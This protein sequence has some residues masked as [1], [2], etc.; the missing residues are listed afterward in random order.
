MESRIYLCV[1]AALA[2]FASPAAEYW[3]RPEL[4]GT[5]F[6]WTKAS[7]Y[8]VSISDASIPEDAP[9][10]ADWIIVNTNFSGKVSY[11][12][13]SYALLANCAHV[14]LQ[15]GSRLE[16]EVAGADTVAEWNSPVNNRIEEMWYTA[17]IAKTGAGTLALKSCNQVPS[18]SGGNVYDY[19]ANLSV[20]GGVLKLPQSTANSTIYSS[21]YSLY[22]AEG[23][24]LEL[25]AYVN[26]TSG[27]YTEFI[28]TISG[29][30]MITN[31]L[32]DAT[33]NMVV[34]GNPAVGYHSVFPG[35]IGGKVS[36]RPY[37]S[38]VDL[39]NTGNTF[40]AS[41][42][43]E[44]TSASRPAIIGAVDVGAA[45]GVPSS[46]GTSS[47]LTLKLHSG[48]MYLGSGPA[49]TTK[50]L[51]CNDYGN[52]FDGGTNGN[53]TL[54]YPRVADANTDNRN[55]WMVFC[56]SNTVDCVYGGGFNA[57][58][59][60][61]HRII[62][63]GPGA[64]LFKDASN[65]RNAGV[66]EVND[67]TLKFESIAETNVVCS[68]GL[69]TALFEKY[70]GA[71]DESR[72]VGY[73]FQLGG[74]NT[75]GTMEYVGET[76]AVCKTRKFALAGDGR[77]KASAG[78]LDLD[79]FGTLNG[80]SATL[81]LAGTG[82]GNVIR[83]L[84]NDAG[85]VTLV[86]EDAG[87]WTLDEEMSFRGDVRVKGG[88]LA[89]KRPDRYGWYRLILKENYYVYTN[90]FP[91]VSYEPAAWMT[92]YFEFAELGLFDAQGTRRNLNLTKDATYQSTKTLSPGSYGFMNY[93]ETATS[94]GRDTGIFS[95]IGY[96]KQVQISANK[97]PSVED[98]TSWPMVVMRLAD[99]TPPI[100]S[101]DFVNSAATANGDADWPCSPTSWELQ[102]S[103]DGK[104]WVSLS[105]VTHKTPPNWHSNWNVRYN[106]T[107][108][109]SAGAK[110]VGYE[111]AGPAQKAVFD[112]VDTV[113]VASGATLS[114]TDGVT[115]NGLSVDVG[116]AGTI[117]GFAFAEEGVLRVENCPSSAVVTL[118]GTYENIAGLSNITNWTLFVNGRE[119]PRRKICVSGDAITL[120]GSGFVISVR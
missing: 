117:S 87:T 14:K 91:G 24:V 21:Y 94:V 73:A 49:T 58:D 106:S 44:A 79:G 46:L 78:A 41:V 50:T 104:T 119:N 97:V 93:N 118:P 63:E 102:G 59:G 6:D 53:F 10:T 15:N 95:D 19:Y 20:E 76:D 82:T 8:Q 111:V 71:I 1:C 70:F 36:V 38:R 34:K 66:I 62:K 61:S 7:S 23:C 31:A 30:G 27:G 42:Q 120:T 83:N 69:S 55:R 29:E 103:L 9:T 80:A 75:T 86:K 37:E 57:Q 16:I 54:S 17:T 92:K 32:A 2:A 96:S 35:R 65:R 101:Y 84:T 39:L 25:G 56:G 67:G 43:C 90:S 12:T 18:D 47:S 98:E 100:A 5:S 74:A 13:D 52:I 115:I 109:F 28:G 48:L 77:L 72:R 51:Y 40:S 99:G 112:N 11:G 107:T 85:R 108:A 26:G 22:V 81:R 64:W 4:S 88:R 60:V 105:S 114:T 33:V 3:T 45:G 110:H 68:L 89:V 116:G 113:G